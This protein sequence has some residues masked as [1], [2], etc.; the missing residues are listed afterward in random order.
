MARLPF[1]LTLAAV[2]LFAAE[3]SAFADAF[4]TIYSVQG[5][6]AYGYGPLLEDPDGHF[7]GAG[8]VGGVAGAG[9]I[10]RYADGVVSEFASLNSLDGSTPNGRLVKGPDGNYYGAAQ[11]GGPNNVGVFFKIT[12]AGELS[13]FANLP[14]DR[15]LGSE[16]DGGLIFDGAGNFFATATAGGKFGYGAVLKISQKGKITVLASLDPAK[17]AYPMGGANGGLVR[18]SAG[19]FY[20]VAA[21]G[22]NGSA[23][24]V[25]FKVTPAGVLS[26]LATFDGT[27][28]ST[29]GGGLLLASDG[30]LYGLTQ[31]G[32]LNT[33]GVVYKVTLPGGVISKVV[34]LQ[35]IPTTPGIYGVGE[36]IEP[37]PTNAPG[38]FYGATEF[39]GANDLGLVFKVTSAGVGTAIASLGADGNEPYAGP[40]LG[41]DGGLWLATVRGGANNEG[42][43]VRVDIGAT[44]ATGKASLGNS[45]GL[46]LTPSLVAGPANSGLLYGAAGRGGA[47]DSGVI[48]KLSQAGAGQAF[49][50]TSVT[51]LDASQN[52]GGPVGPLVLADDG[53][54]YG[55]AQGSPTNVSAIFQVSLPGGQASVAKVIPGNP[56]VNGL[57]LGGDGSYYGTGAPNSADPH[58]T[59]FRFTIP[60]QIATPFDFTGGL[61]NPAGAL[62]EGLDGN[63]YG[64]CRGGGAKNAG[65]VFQVTTDGIFSTLASFTGKNGAAPIGAMARGFGG[66]FYGAA[67][68]GGAFGYGAVYSVNANGKL[69]AVASFNGFNGAYPSAGLVRGPGG[70]FY[71]TAY[72]GG[73]KGL[74]TVFKVSPSGKLTVIASFDGKTNGAFPQSTMIVG[75]DG[76]IYGTTYSTVYQITPAASQPPTATNVNLTL[77]VFGVSLAKYA[78]DP[79]GNPLEVVA[80][81]EAAHGSVT[82]AVDGTIDYLPDP[83]FTNTD[84]FS[85]TVSDGLGHSA[86]AQVTVTAP[87]NN[88]LAGAGLYAGL[89]SDANSPVGYWGIT[90][91]S[92]GSFTGV[93]SILGA[94]YPLKGNFNSSGVFNQTITVNGQSFQCNLSINAGLNQITGTVMANNVSYSLTL[95]RTFPQF[96]AKSPTPWAGR[97]TLLIPV[98]AAQ[99]GNQSY[100][101][102]TG[103]GVMTITPTGLVTVIGKLGDGAS[104]TVGTVLSRQQVIPFFSQVA[105]QPGGYIAGLVTLARAV[106]SDMTGTLAWHKPPQTSPNDT[107]TFDLTPSLIGARYTPPA[108]NTIAAPFR[109]VDSARV[110]N[111]SL[112]IGVVP[113]VQFVIASSNK[114][115][116]VSATPEQ[117]LLK[118]SAATGLFTGSFL[119]SSADPRQTFAGV[120]FQKGA[121]PHGE[122]ETSNGSDSFVVT[123]TPH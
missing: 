2:S 92:K 8:A 23:N 38:V 56:N 69:A 88:V 105:Y 31:H 107:S 55:T 112:T 6:A 71:G 33:F 115:K 108:P 65:A 73:K 85:Y 67:E 30:N 47:K 32:G 95:D 75:S 82:L 53:N 116:P 43:V 79:S 24:S 89:V 11:S 27:N 59:V 13:T 25:V 110:F 19:N 14:P 63:L 51:A 91:T 72:T 98:P 36:L 99:K 123:L 94:K 84:A 119:P 106:E 78:S 93:L 74:G 113:A 21:Y 87:A 81:G 42:A 54:L 39:G 61:S 22:P 15:S 52:V 62:V 100:P 50:F 70:N 16:P 41:K 118:I 68:Q 83:T 20:G 101:Q 37:D 1:L 7:I 109:L 45:K 60:D 120:L 64:T 90:L 66:A 80:V 114:A 18:D 97:Y 4:N 96:T 48:Y 44:T 10:Y 12:P 104:Y 35:A 103:Y 26:T 28:E 5:P 40:I 86:T 29:A 76:N 46:D 34:D 77:P 122:G 3:R 49:V 17:M 121:T 117:P 57:T 102:G 9:A 58:S 111:A